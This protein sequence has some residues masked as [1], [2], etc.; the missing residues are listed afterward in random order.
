MT[1]VLI[2]DM[3]ETLRLYFIMGSNNC[4]MDPEYVLEQAIKGGI[5]FFQFREKG[6][7]ALT[8]NEK[9]IF[10]KRLQSICQKYSIPFIVNDDVELAISLNADGV[11]IGQGDESA[12]EVRRKIGDKILGVSAHTVEEVE[13]AIA[14]GADYVGIGPIYSTTTKEDAKSPQ[15]TT[16]INEVRKK[17]I[18]IPIVGIGGITAENA[19]PVMESG[20]NG[21]S[22]ISAIS[23]AND[24]AESAR[25]LKEAI[26]C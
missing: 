5:S 21:I 17:G 2:K 9:V 16:I 24:P 3:C 22:V 13:K 6:T 11:H 18:E 4:T 15:G 25:E 19:L 23:R 26:D 12:D 10:A 1:K 14:N 20:G 8:G 7:D